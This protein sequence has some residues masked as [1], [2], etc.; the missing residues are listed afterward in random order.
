MSDANNPAT[1]RVVLAFFLD[2]VVSFLIFGY[3][4]ALVTGDT[5]QGGFQLNGAPAILLFALVIAYMVLMPRVG[6]RVFQRFLR[7]R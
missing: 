6:G 1:W 4:I 3:I 7:A 2:L 5:T